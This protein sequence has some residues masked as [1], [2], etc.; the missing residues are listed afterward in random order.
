MRSLTRM[1]PTIN[2]SLD[3][4]FQVCKTRLKKL[5]TPYLNETLALE[6]RGG[7]EYTLYHPGK[8]VRPMFVYATGLLFDAPWENMDVPASAIEL[9]H[10]Y[11]LI[12]DD[13]PC[14]DNAELRRGQPACHKVYGEGMA[15]LTGDAL[16][17]LAIEIM[18]HH[19]ALL[20][21]DRRLQMI[22]A[23]SKACGPFGMAAGQALDLSILQ[24]KNLSLD[25]IEKIY[26]LKTGALLSACIELGRLSSADDDSFNQQALAQFGKCIGLA[27]QIQ[28]DIL[29]IE[30]FSEL[31]GK[32][33]GLDVKNEK[34]TYP[35]LCGLEKAKD[36]VQ[37]LYQEALEA[38][39]Y[40]GNK[41]QLLRELTNCLLQRRK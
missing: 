12:H 25:L 28:D 27:F 40:L 1:N 4:L 19:P 36:K 26:Q 8:H 14:M 15:M 17:T 5:Y 6:L 23:L 41:A 35:L 34:M 10:T 3:K 37:V 11:S 22:S 24:D 39:N 30:S 21:A 16:H 33:Q 13:L 18:A 29:D 38:I 9:I 7:M 32:P 31:S 20:L 2:I